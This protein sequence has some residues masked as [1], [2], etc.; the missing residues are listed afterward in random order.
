[1]SPWRQMKRRRKRSDENLYSFGAF[2]GSPLMLSGFAIQKS[3][4]GG[5]S[6]QEA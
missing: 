1:M 3:L 5:S 6:A 2:E 4:P